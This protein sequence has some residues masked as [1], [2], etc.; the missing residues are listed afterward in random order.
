MYSDVCQYISSCITC[1]Q[2]KRLIHP[3]EAPVHPLPVEIIFRRWH[4]DALAP[5]PKSKEGYIYIILCVE[6]STRWPEIHP[7]KKLEAEEIA[8]VIFNQAFTR[9]GPSANL[10][11]ERGTSFIGRVVTSL[12]QAFR[13]TRL[14][15][16]IFTHKAM[17]HEISLIATSVHIVPIKRNGQI[18]YPRLQW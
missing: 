15:H 6:S 3:A 1:Q 4:C 7:V 2:M 8:D 11:S 18:I 16:Q 10:M 14:K 17:Q 12:C 13:V 9:F 5:L